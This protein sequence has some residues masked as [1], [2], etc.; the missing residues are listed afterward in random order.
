MVPPPVAPDLLVREQRLAKACNPKDVHAILD[1]LKD[2]ANRGSQTCSMRIVPQGAV[3]FRRLDENTWVNVTQS[4][5]EMFNQPCHITLTSTLWR[6]S[7]RDLWNFSDAR[8][9]SPNSSAQ[10]RA[11]DIRRDWTWFDH[12]RF[13]VPCR[14]IGP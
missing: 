6:S 5:Y 10:C 1:I 4:D 13:E 11:M 12:N 2:D 3:R 9:A 8:A 7:K 14:Y